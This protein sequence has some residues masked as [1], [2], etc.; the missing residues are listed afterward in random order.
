MNKPKWWNTGLELVQ[1]RTADCSHLLR[2]YAAPGQRAIE[3]APAR[4]LAA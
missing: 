2:L 3:G 4:G 1:R